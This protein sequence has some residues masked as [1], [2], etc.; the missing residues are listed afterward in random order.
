MMMAQVKSGGRS[1]ARH[2][3]QMPANAIGLPPLSLKWEAT[4][5]RFYAAHAKDP[6]AGIQHLFSRKAWSKGAFSEMV[7]ALALM[8]FGPES[9]SL[10]QYGMN[11][12]L[13]LARPR[14]FPSGFRPM[15]AT[16]WVGATLYRGWSSG[17]PNAAAS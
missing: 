13:S 7:P 17:R 3:S 10:A 16:N 6:S 14:V 4:L 9:G 1:S 8:G 2:T 5:R 11:P 12:H 15:T